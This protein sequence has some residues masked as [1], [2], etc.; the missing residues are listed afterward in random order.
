MTDSFPIYFETHGNPKHPCIIM[1]AGIGGQLL[2]WQPTMIQRLSSAGFY[3]VVFD[4]RD[5]GLSKKYDELGKVDFAAIIAAT[6]QGKAVLPPYTL[7]NMAED[8][9]TLMDELHVEQ[10]HILG[11]SMGGMIAQY[12][13]INHPDR[14]H[15]LICMY[16]TSGD[17]TLPPGAQAVQEYYAGMISANPRSLEE[18]INSK[19]QYFKIINHP[20]YFDEAKTKEQL[21]TAFKRSYHPEAFKR[22]L[23]AMIS[24]QPRTEKLKQ[25]HIPT[26]IIHG[27]YDPVFPVEHGKHLAEVI[28]NSQLAI[29]PKLGHGLPDHF[30]EEITKLI[31]SFIMEKGC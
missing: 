29:I 23:L 24:E 28:P 7:E 27:D 21:I 17:A 13:A 2:D 1:I 9:I 30:I 26:L 3:V 16:S 25:L 10:A 4:N 15:S 31:I 20:D 12:V 6:Q 19:L 11:A 22:I 18:G 14:V 8:V 5:C